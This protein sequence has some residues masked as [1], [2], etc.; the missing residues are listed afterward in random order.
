MPSFE[1]NPQT[2]GYKILS[3]KT[4]DLESLMQPMVK[5]FLILACTVLIQCQGVTDRW[6][7]R[8]TNR[9]MPRRWIR[10][11]KHSAIVRKNKT[12]AEMY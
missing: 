3:G 10:P 11:A 9:Q 7:D 6:T 5:I 1:G 8:R 12:S 2:K 4:R